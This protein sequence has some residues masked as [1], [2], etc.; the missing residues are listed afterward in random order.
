MFGGHHQNPAVYVTITSFYLSNVFKCV[1]KLSSGFILIKVI[2]QQ[3]F[4]C[5]RR[6]L[7]TDL[8]T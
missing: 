3:V 7:I 4:E 2:F 6:S 8:V 5:R 1:I